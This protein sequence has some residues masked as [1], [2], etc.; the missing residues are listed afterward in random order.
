M[1][2]DKDSDQNLDLALLDTSALAFIE[3]FYLHAMRIK[4]SCAG[5]D[6]PTFLKF[7]PGAC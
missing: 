2:V 4:T 6:F 5:R 1:N 3:G 7:G